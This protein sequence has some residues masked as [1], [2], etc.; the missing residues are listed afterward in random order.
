M[1]KKRLDYSQPGHQKPM[2]R[3]NSKNI[4]EAVRY[5]RKMCNIRQSDL[6]YASGVQIYVI[7][8]IENGK[9]NPK[10]ETLGKLFA[11]MNMT[12]LEGMERYIDFVRRA[13]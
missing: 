3:V 9:G 2:M 12:I 11:A 4:G 8:Q 7:S 1:S 13:G 5:N 6:V 10:L